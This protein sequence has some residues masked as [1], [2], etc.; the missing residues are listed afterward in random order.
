MDLFAEDLNGFL[1][2]LGITRPVVLAGLSMGG[3]IAMA[4][5]R[6][7]ATRMAGIILAATR[8]GA[9][10]TEAKENRDKAAAQARNEGK[11]GIIESMLAKMLAPRAYSQQPE[12]VE[13]VRNIM[14]TTSIE[15]ILGDLAGMKERPDST[16]TLEEIE[17]PALIIHGADDQIIPVKEAEQ[18]QESLSNSR[19][20]I[21]P[22][23]GHLVSLEQP[24][25]FNQVV[26]RFVQSL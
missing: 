9:D 12:L 2:A 5:Y 18:M 4:F 10:S 25:L 16:R 17:L 6:Q 8:A 3:Y 1:D 14:E 21:L 24:E 20:E 19:L 26:R 22:D 13:R 23:A 15:G 7:F 11:S